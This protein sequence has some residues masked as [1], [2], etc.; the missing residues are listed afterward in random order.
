MIKIPAN[1]NLK[2]IYGTNELV[3]LRKKIDKEFLCLAIM[4]KEISDKGF[5]NSK[6]FRKT[7]RKFSKK[8]MALQ[9]IADNAKSITDEIKK[10]LSCLK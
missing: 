3:N 2:I 4:A 10:A 8:I 1:P 5:K 9:I 6:T 7:F